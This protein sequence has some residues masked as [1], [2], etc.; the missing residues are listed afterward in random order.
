[1]PTFAARSSPISVAC[2]KVAVEIA[3][4]RPVG[5]GEATVGA[6]GRLL[7]RLADLDIRTDIRARQR[8]DLQVRD[9][10][11]HVG[12]GFEEVLIRV[13]ALDQPLAVV[14]PVDAD[15]QRAAHQ[16]V[17]HALHHFRLRSFDRLLLHRADVDAD[18][19]HFGAD[20]AIA[21]AD[22]AVATQRF[23]TAQ[24]LD[25]GLERAQIVLRL[26]AHDVVARQVAQ[27]L[28]VARQHAQQLDVGKRDVQEEAERPFHAELAQPPAERDQV[29]V[30]RPDHVVLL[31]ER[32]ELLREHA[33][34]V[35]VCV[36][37]LG[38]VAHAALEVVEQ[39]PQ[40]F[41]RVAVVVELELVLLEIDRRVGDAVADVDVGIAR[42]VL[43]A[44]RR[45]SR[46]TIRRCACSA[47]RMPIAS[48]PGA[49][50][51]RGSEIRFETHTSRLILRV[52]LE[53]NGMPP[54]RWE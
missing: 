36:A 7:Q 31:E 11:E 16:A 47:L 2:G 27:Q 10:A 4:R 34:H 13:E 22:A 19:K 28:R 32:C 9:A 1:M 43:D 14:E 17:G 30:V 51:L 38:R 49:A 41:V 6:A 3:D 52:S 24:V 15:H 25:A 50:D 53:A 18:R 26:E 33:I 29:I 44:S 21:D 12:I 20:D 40:N 35:L 54:C 37:L 5:V 39:R 48:P 23:R 8:R 42:L 46:T 45:P